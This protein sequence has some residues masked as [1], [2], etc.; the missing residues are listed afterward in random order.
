MN[1]FQKSKSIKIII[2]IKTKKSNLILYSSNKKSESQFRFIIKLPE[3]GIKRFV[4]CKRWKFNEYK[5]FGEKIKNIDFY[6]FIKNSKYN[7]IADKM[8][9]SIID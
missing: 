3:K 4:H 1:I 7:Q 9:I 5:F 6:F 8:I 2:Y